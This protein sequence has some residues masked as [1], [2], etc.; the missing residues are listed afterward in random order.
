M[1]AGAGMQMLGFFLMSQ[2]HSDS[3]QW[4]V[5]W[6]MFIVGIGLGPSQSLFNMVSQSAAPVRQIG[7]ATSTGMFLRQ[8]GGMIGVSILGAMLLAKVAE[9]IAEKFPGITVDL[10][11]LQRMAM[12]GEGGA[13]SPEIE[14]FVATSISNA[15]SYIFLGAMIILIGAI[16][17]IFFIPQITLRGREP[18]QNLEK[19]AE[20]AAPAGPVTRDAPATAA[21]AD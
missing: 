8:C 20:G 14:Q 4:D 19:A 18:G 11:Q 3:H 7:V 9:A 21:K 13:M 10:G 1:F 6:R 5:T 16:A 12:A 17:A 2:L 15:M